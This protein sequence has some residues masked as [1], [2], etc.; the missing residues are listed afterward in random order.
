MTLSQALDLLALLWL[1][2]LWL[3]CAAAIRR[4]ILRRCLPGGWRGAALTAAAPLTVG[5]GLAILIGAGIAD[6]IRA[7]LHRQEGDR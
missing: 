1:V 6:R 4:A 7:A 3:A 2:T 5:A